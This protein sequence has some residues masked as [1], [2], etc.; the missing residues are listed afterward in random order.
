MNYPSKAEAEAAIQLFFMCPIPRDLHRVKLIDKRCQDWSS[1][2]FRSAFF[3]QSPTSEQKI[4][5]PSP[6]INIAR[7][8]REVYVHFTRFELDCP[9]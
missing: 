4:S 7:M 3:I 5:P 6:A 8:L 9:Y 1:K 2:T